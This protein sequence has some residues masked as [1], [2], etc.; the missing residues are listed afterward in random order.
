MRLPLLH[1]YS[2]LVLTLGLLSAFL[3]TGSSHAQPERLVLA[4]TTSVQN[5]G[6]L[7]VLLPVF[8]RRYGY[9]VDVIAVG[10]GAA[11]KLAERG[12]ADVLIAHAP[13]SEL[14]LLEA[15]GVT[16]RHFVMHNDFVF[17]GPMDDPAGVASATG[18]VE[19]LERIREAGALF[20]SRGDDS[21]TH[22]KERVLWQISEHMPDWG[23]YLEVGQGMEATLVVAH[24]KRAYTLTDRGT[25]LALRDRLDLV[26]VFEGDDLLYNPYHVMATNPEKHP[27]VNHEGALALITFLTS[28]EGQVLIGSFRVAGVPLFTPAR[29]V[30]D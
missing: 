30:T 23:K 4:T 27:G 24:E 14:L 25:F 7:D 16:E 6:L 28:P 11:L 3:S 18:A 5:S 26:V 17:V 15:G 2:T 19:A 12:D 8:S 9:M 13:E 20:V 22:Q 29:A 1:P 21:G 10:S